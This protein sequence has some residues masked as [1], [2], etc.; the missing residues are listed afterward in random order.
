[1]TGNIKLN[2]ILNQFDTFAKE[3]AENGKLACQFGINRADGT[4]RIV[5]PTDK[6]AYKPT[7]RQNNLTRYWFF[8][9][10]AARFGGA[11]KIPPKVQAALRK[12]GFGDVTFSEK[13]GGEQ[14]VSGK[15]LQVRNITA[16][17]RAVESAVKTDKALNADDLARSVMDCF[18]AGNLTK[19]GKV[20]PDKLT[21]A[22]KE[23][24]DAA[25]PPK[26]QTSTHWN[27][28]PMRLL[29]VTDFAKLQEGIYNK[30]NDVVGEI[31]G[32]KFSA[33]PD[34]ARKHCLT[35]M[36][37]VVE[38]LKQVFV[39]SKK[40][41]G[42]HVAQYQNRVAGLCKEY[43]PDLKVIYGSA[44]EST[45]DANYKLNLKGSTYTELIGDRHQFEFHAKAYEVGDLNSANEFVRDLLH[46]I[47]IA[48]TKDGGNHAVIDWLGDTLRET[49]EGHL[50]KDSGANVLQTMCRLSS[51]GVNGE[52]VSTVR[53]QLSIL[54]GQV[55][56]VLNGDAKAWF[57]EVMAK[58]ESFG[59][60]SLDVLLYRH[61]LTTLF[62]SDD[63]ETF[64]SI[65]SCVFGSGSGEG[66]TGGAGYVGLLPDDKA[67]KFLTKWTQR[68]GVGNGL[69]GPEKANVNAATDLLRQKLLEFAAKVGPH[70]KD[71]VAKMLEKKL[72]NGVDLL[73]RTDVA[74]AIDFLAPY[75]VDNKGKKS[76]WNRL[77]ADDARRFAGESNLKEVSKAW[78]EAG[79]IAVADGQDG[80]DA[81]KKIRVED[82]GKEA[83]R[84]GI[85]FEKQADYSEEEFKGQ[86]LGILKE[87][88]PAD[89]REAI[90]L[91]LEAFTK[92]AKCFAA[93]TNAGKKAYVE[94]YNGNLAGIRSVEEYGDKVCSLVLKGQGLSSVLKNELT[95]IKFAVAAY[96]NGE[97]TPVQLSGDHKTESGQ[98]EHF[99]NQGTDHNQTDNA[100]TAGQD[101]HQVGEEKGNL[102]EKDTLGNAESGSKPET[103]P[104]TKSEFEPEEVSIFEEGTRKNT[105][106]DTDTKKQ[107]DYY[108]ILN[109]GETDTDTMDKAGQHGIKGQMPSLDGVRGGINLIANRID[110]NKAT[111]VSVAFKD[112]CRNLP[113][114]DIRKIEQL[115][116]K[117]R[118]DLNGNG[119]SP[120]TIK[121]QLQNISDQ[122]YAL[123]EGS[124]KSKAI[125]LLLGV[126][127]HF[128]R[129]E[130]ARPRTQAKGVASKPSATTSANSNPQPRKKVGNAD[131]AQKL[132][133]RLR[134][135]VTVGRNAELMETKGKNS[136]CLFYSILQGL[137]KAQDDD[138]AQKLRVQLEE[139]AL[140][141]I[142]RICKAKGI[143][144]KDAYQ[145]IL[146]LKAAEE[147]GLPAGLAQSYDFL[148]EKQE[149][150]DYFIDSA[151]SAG[152]IF[153]P[154]QLLAYVPDLY[155]RPV[156]VV[157]AMQ[158]ETSLSEPDVFIPSSEDKEWGDP[159]CIYFN[160]DPVFGH[161]QTIAYE[162][163][164]P[165]ENQ[166]QVAQSEEVDNPVNL[167][168]AQPVNEIEEVEIQQ[169]GRAANLGFGPQ[170]KY[171]ADA[172]QAEIRKVLTAANPANMREA[173]CVA[174]NAF[175]RGDKCL[176]AESTDG[177]QRYLRLL[178]Q[179]GAEPGFQADLGPDASFECYSRAIVELAT[180]ND[181]SLVFKKELAD[182]GAAIAAYCKSK[183]TSD[184]TAKAA[185][186]AGLYGGE[187]NGLYDEGTQG[188]ER[189]AI[190]PTNE[191]LDESLID[192]VAI[193]GGET[194]APA[195]TLTM[196]ELKR[197]LTSD[198]QAA[199]SKLPFPLDSPKAKRFADMV[200]RYADEVGAHIEI[201]SNGGKPSEQDRLNF[202]MIV[203]EIN[204]QLGLKGNDWSVSRQKI[205]RAVVAIML[206][207][208]E[209]K[210]ILGSPHKIDKDV[211]AQLANYQV[212]VC[213]QKWQN[214][215]RN[216]PKAFETG[217][218][219]DFVRCQTDG[220]MYK[221]FTFNGVG[222]PEGKEGEELAMGGQQVSWKNSGLQR[223]MKG[224]MAN[225]KIRAF[226]TMMCGLEGLASAVGEVARRNPDTVDYG[227][228][229]ALDIMLSQ[230][231]N[232]GFHDG[233]SVKYDLT[234]EQTDLIF[235]MSVNATPIVRTLFQGVKLD[236]KNHTA[237]SENRIELK[238]RIPLNQE[239][240]GDE[241]PKYEIV[242]LSQTIDGE[243]GEVYRPGED[244][245]K[246]EVQSG[247]AQAGK[248]A[249]NSADKPAVVDKS[250]VQVPKGVSDGQLKLLNR[251][252]AFAKGKHE[253]EKGGRGYM[254]IGEDGV[255][256]KYLTHG[257]KFDSTKNA[258]DNAWIEASTENLRK[259]I[260]DMAANFGDD[261]KNAVEGKL[262]L[263]KIGGVKFLSRES[264][265]SAI[266]ELAKSIPEFKWSDVRN[267][268][269]FDKSSVDEI[270]KFHDLVTSG[271][272]AVRGLLA[273]NNNDV[274]AA[275]IAAI[276]KLRNDAKLQENLKDV[277]L[278]LETV[279]SVEKIG[280]MDES[281]KISSNTFESHVGGVTETASNY[282]FDTAGIPQEE[283][284]YVILNPADATF[285]GG[286]LGG[287]ATSLEE[288]ELQDMNPVLGALFMAHGLVEKHND[289]NLIYH[290][291]PD[292]KGDVLSSADGYIVDTTMIGLG[293]QQLQKKPAKVKV[294]FGA[295]VS[296]APDGT[297]KDE[298]GY[299]AYKVKNDVKVLGDEQAR[300]NLVGDSAKT[301]AEKRLGYVNFVMEM[302]KEILKLSDE[303]SMTADEHMKTGLRQRTYRDLMKIV[304]FGKNNL[305]VDMSGKN[306]KENVAAA[307]KILRD[308]NRRNKLLVDAQ[309]NYSDTM[310]FTFKN[311]FELAGAQGAT[312]VQLC[313]IGVDAFG[314]SPREIAEMMAEMAILHGKNVKGVDMKFTFG[315]YNGNNVMAPL[316]EAAFV[317]YANQ[318]GVAQKPG[319][320]SLDTANA[321]LKY[322]AE[323]EDELADKNGRRKD[324]YSVLDTMWK[325][326]LTEPPANISPKAKSPVARQFP[327]DMELKI[328][329]E[330]YE[331]DAPLGSEA[332]GKTVLGD[333]DGMQEHIENSVYAP[334]KSLLN[335]EK[336][337]ENIRDGY[338]YALNLCS[339]RLVQFKGENSVADA[340][341]K[342]AYRAFLQTAANLLANKS[343]TGIPEK[344]MNLL[345]SYKFETW[346]DGVK[347]AL[348]AVEEYLSQ[349]KQPNAFG[350]G[351]GEVKSEDG[352][353]EDD[354]NSKV[355]GGEQH[356]KVKD[357]VISVD[358][359]IEQSN[360]RMSGGRM[361]D[362]PVVG[363]FGNEE[364]RNPESNTLTAEDDG[365]LPKTDGRNGVPQQPIAEVI[366]VAD[367]KIL[368]LPPENSKFI[369]DDPKEKH[370][371]HE[372]LESAENLVRNRLEEELKNWDPSMGTKKLST[373]EKEEA[374][375]KYRNDLKKIFREAREL[376]TGFNAS[377]KIV[378]DKNGNVRV[379]N[380]GER[381]SFL[382]VVYDADSVDGNTI[383]KA[384]REQT[385]THGEENVT[386]VAK[387][388]SLRF[389]ELMDELRKMIGSKV[390]HLVDDLEY[391]THGHKSEP[392]WSSV[393]SWGSLIEDLDKHLAGRIAVSEEANDERKIFLEDRKSSIAARGKRYTIVGERLISTCTELIEKYPNIKAMLKKLSSLTQ[394]EQ[395]KLKD[396]VVAY[397]KDF[398]SVERDYQTM[399]RAK[400]KEWLDFY[401]LNMFDCIVALNRK[402]TNPRDAIKAP[403][404]Y[405]YLRENNLLYGSDNLGS[406]VRKVKGSGKV[407]AVQYKKGELLQGQTGFATVW[408]NPNLDVNEIKGVG[409]GGV[410]EPRDPK[411]QSRI[412]EEDRKDRVNK[413]ERKYTEVQDG[414][415]FQLEGKKTGKKEKGVTFNPEIKE[416]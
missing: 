71:V 49:F 84:K 29:G 375:A 397:F 91:A 388:S 173:I 279:G 224:T 163:V 405:K 356:D 153:A 5:E 202:E 70:A 10:V 228:G 185:G 162:K 303:I 248:P 94:W 387:P 328:P 298:N 33:N 28:H 181:N 283:V 293:N 321:I 168:V 179:V 144:F 300:A 241:M 346:A 269:T 116:E 338:A 389:Y 104:G 408:Q 176:A 275:Q 24:F 320:M 90:R 174:L 83:G 100:K 413:E 206:K 93:E 136:N 86:I 349:S 242:S 314:N 340:K 374:K 414:P 209:A 265:A 243:A 99:K 8:Q 296:F 76:N 381:L 398:R 309:K 222:A 46:A 379:V 322:A 262:T 172:F 305:G 54:N 80:N 324:V 401:Q 396:D 145:S 330:L 169:L 170:E 412:Q 142:G 341:G 82:L 323:R 329:V 294:L 289:G 118:V 47:A 220:D 7:E 158:G 188:E 217:F 121:V 354:T 20:D 27:D 392:G 382:D 376:A 276:R 102:F 331:N 252:A 30:I 77:T 161:F 87:K 273:K 148:A 164:V 157:N 112:A 130:V 101:A 261:V 40:G 364:N 140:E 201:I 278:K 302:R 353:S 138:A 125:D 131:I 345:S 230:L 92:G 203:G 268:G 256:L 282:V 247:Q 370:T 214:L 167:G 147:L 120:E 111:S 250:E 208:E 310:K 386:D 48:E 52:L 171:S 372:R 35:W 334:M 115:L 223:M 59:D 304:L 15:S 332:D 75:L 190:H 73:A 177:K 32:D 316:L 127:L 160:G 402:M 362:N 184:A 409:T 68:S 264:V 159:I 359:L 258:E 51:K 233:E 348:K 295:G 133:G 263:K 231:F 351:V 95:D 285:W 385:S 384:N 236:P 135:G 22:L 2:P 336:P 274:H 166:G 255:L 260:L 377:S 117:A 366:P 67:F 363:A 204:K 399:S 213:A 308:E 369:L 154:E 69:T 18:T 191:R 109:D 333:I 143:E 146:R 395:N 383:P 280:T 37:S 196:D 34:E 317:K 78:L 307:M 74:K 297:S 42:V 301:K 277:E 342:N 312:H 107:D 26:W 360:L 232:G 319:G 182:M 325:Q 175:S 152:N 197:F 239:L 141:D 178:R 79:G 110:S 60:K 272:D 155:N 286:Y 249:V 367:E 347:E 410:L 235:T 165:V 156:V 62:S 267:A 394:D 199:L 210:V 61:G 53:T 337:V 25:M 198:E 318:Y 368:R 41:K 371:L 36:N 106:T 58:V 39:E 390:H 1:M 299:F 186:N 216:E 113:G 57:D 17:I 227:Y 254:G 212:E 183:G 81:V 271:Q 55:P 257:E 98:P 85:G 124:F 11:D 246:V 6:A 215:L 96:F 306:I 137:G 119:A 400:K 287:Q 380:D 134:E 3:H 326:G 114:E 129:M 291:V 23:F 234:T 313:G 63:L 284:V 45:A 123:E 72:T 352:K 89:V 357:G 149:V 290:Y 44:E 88:N 50:Q 16:V 139:L 266:T 211:L 335:Q 407:D 251:I 31:K 207:N 97:S 237:V 150:L 103:E 132:S 240:N 219:G 393:F 404:M 180:D 406:I 193:D 238:M 128:K 281:K 259:A 122:V 21:K 105:K 358:E 19:D 270:R 311:W 194:S 226:V 245:P 288:Q 200:G 66:K 355:E 391:E 253:G 218:G 415:T 205:V 361:D 365:I 38:D 195:A 187:L 378:E 9:G 4:S 315:N 225:P 13:V 65:A 43:V 350:E 108:P 56:K 12:N 373:K 292:E 343:A 14:F 344:I 339:R 126:A 229:K 151:R 64:D 221:R 327:E 189:P 244:L 403:E 192:N 416:G 411:K